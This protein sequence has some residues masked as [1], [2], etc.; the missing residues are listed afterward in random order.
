MHEDAPLDVCFLILLV[1][2][3]LIINKKIKCRH[4][5]ES[6]SVSFYLHDNELISHYELQQKS[7]LCFSFNH[8]TIGQAK[9]QRFLAVLLNLCMTATKA[10]FRLKPRVNAL[11]DLI[12]QTKATTV[13][14]TLFT[15][16]ALKR[17]TFHC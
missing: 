12:Q 10:A 17:L 5:Q 8:T 4:K 11:R 1:R 13:F 7:V 14:R 9:V 6:Y 2:I 3:C 15:G 16:D